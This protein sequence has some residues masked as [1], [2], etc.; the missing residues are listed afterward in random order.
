MRAT[1]VDRLPAAEGYWRPT[2]PLFRG[3][4][5]F[6]RSEKF[7]GRFSLETG[8]FSWFIE[9]TPPPLFGSS[10]PRWIQQCGLSLW[11]NDTESILAELVSNGAG[12]LLIS[13]RNA[14]TGDPLWEKLIPIPDGAEWAESTPAWPGASTEEIY[15]FLADD[16]KYLVICLLRQS[17]CTG[18]ID[19][20]DGIDVVT[21]P[22]FRSQLDA[23]RLDP[24]SGIPHW[25]ISHQGLFVGILERISF[26]GIWSHNSYAGNLDLETGEN[27]ALHESSGKLGWPVRHKGLIAIPWHSRGRVGV[28]WI[29][30]DGVHVRSSE[31]PH[32]RVSNTKLHVTQGGLC[33]QV[34]DQI[35][36]WLGETMTPLWSVTAK[37]IIWR[38]HCVPD[39]CVFVGTN[40]RLLAFDQTSG[41]EQLNLKPRAGGAEDLTKVT[42]HD[43]LVATTR[44]SQSWTIPTRLLVL[45][46]ADRTHTCELECAEI[47]AAWEHGILCLIGEQGKRLT[48]VDIRP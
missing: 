36:W 21:Y 41:S 2:R 22:P 39:S 27:K 7:I 48:I 42:G 14:G 15:G 11:L 38:V 24:R 44:V 12:D 3:T 4:S 28:E 30:D 16:P 1:L 5:A 9:R 31:W 23:L 29:D 6:V 47:F 46:M 35:L 43:V 18:L 32:K 45:S 37:P 17:R 10:G 8:K 33:L 26:K 20:E 19:P 34:N 13:A 40:G 25:H